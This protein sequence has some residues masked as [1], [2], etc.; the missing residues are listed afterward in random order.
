MKYCWNE[1]ENNGYDPCDILL[2]HY[3][4]DGFRTIALRKEAFECL[5]PWQLCN[6][7]NIAYD[8]GRKAAMED[9]RRFIGVKE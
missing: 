5:T 6:M 4:D 9:L 8:N 7:M 1:K 3:K 2:Q